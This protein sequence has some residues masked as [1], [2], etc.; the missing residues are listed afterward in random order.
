MLSHLSKVP[1]A[2]V[3]R[4]LSSLE[5]AHI[6]VPASYELNSPLIKVKGIGKSIRIIEGRHR[7]RHVAF[8]GTN[9]QKYRFLLTSQTD[10]KLDERFMQLFSFINGLIKKSEIRFRSK[11]TVQTLKVVPVSARVGL[12]EWVSG[13]ITLDDVLRES[14]KKLGLDVDIDGKA[15]SDFQKAIASAP[16]DDLEK[17]I[18]RGSANM[19][20]WIDRRLNFTSSLASNSVIGYV[21]GL[22]NRHMRNIQINPSTAALS[23]LDFSECFE[24]ALH[25]SKFPETV[26]FRLTRL[27]TNA[28][29]FSG[30]SGTFKTSSVSVLK[31]LKKDSEQILGLLDVFSSDPVFPRMTQLPI[32]ERMRQKLSGLDPGSQKVKSADQIELLVRQATSPDHLA[33]M[34]RGWM[35]WW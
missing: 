6:I 32:F 4:F 13:R 2:F 8:I 17:Y 1:T 19:E 20:V 33:K 5:N 18:L 28:L 15:G 11:L 7:V 3:S 16:A 26:P 14:R 23:H 12:V 29:E 34:W 22:G 31:L 27:L 24:A 10:M 25:R 35:P 9:G 21:I 30:V